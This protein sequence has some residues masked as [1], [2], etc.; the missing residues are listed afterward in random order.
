MNHIIN[1]VI[2]LFTLGIFI[3]DLLLPLG[4]AAG[5]PYGLVVMV[6]LW[7]G[8]YLATYLVTIAGVVLTIIGFFLSPATVSAMHAVLINR[9]LAIVIIVATAIMVIQRKKA[10]QKIS[11]LGT[12]TLTDTLTKLRNRRAFNA[13][14]PVEIERAKRY[15]RSLSLAMIDLD[16]FKLVND[17]FGHEEGDLTLKSFAYELSSNTRQSDYIFRLG[18]DEFAI[19]FTESD[20]TQATASCEKIRRIH[21]LLAVQIGDSKTTLSIGLTTLRNDDDIHSLAKRA[22]DALYH[23]KNHGRNRVSISED[24]LPI[25]ESRQIAKG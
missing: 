25:V 15:G 5:T 7:S 9:A 4:V 21:E 1:A 22:D 10:D 23:A 17:T 12:Q 6:T 19:I 16:H 20:L 3:M 14:L 13:T 11:F 24:D 2:V 18:G 8:T